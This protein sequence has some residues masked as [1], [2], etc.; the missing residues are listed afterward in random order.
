MGTKSKR[1]NISSITNKKGKEL[2]TCVAAYTHPVA[3][4]IDEFCDIIL[5]GDSLGMTI[6]GMNNTLGVTLDMMIN[7]G[8]AVVNATKKSLIVV[9]LP[10]GSYETSKEQAL[11][12]S[13]EV[14]A[15]TGCEAVKLEIKNDDL[16][17]TI[18]FLNQ[19]GI[20]VVSHVGLTPQNIKEMGG[21]KVQGRDK[22]TAQKIIDLAVKSQDAGAFC[23]VIE[24]VIEEIAS[25]ITNKLTIPTIGIGASPHCDGQVLVIDDILGIQQEYS[26]RFVKK[27]ANLSQDISD[28]VKNFSNDVKNKKF[29]K[30]EHCFFPK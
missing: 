18:K 15:K 19:K 28:A 16:I 14:V 12:T 27:Y 26:P 9:D 10:Y 8:K 6:Y 7:H 5:V 25:K 20:K 22:K 1:N 2:I 24:G 11:K 29:P 3:K 30:E 4:L 17:K 21:F 13:L 23:V